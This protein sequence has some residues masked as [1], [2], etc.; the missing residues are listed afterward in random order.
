M[1]FIDNK[2]WFRVYCLDI[3]QLP[4][5]EYGCLSAELGSLEQLS[6]FFLGPTH[7]C[8]GPKHDSLGHNNGCYGHRTVC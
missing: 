3:I 5:P 2:N 8:L 6:S 1:L 7:A 4:I